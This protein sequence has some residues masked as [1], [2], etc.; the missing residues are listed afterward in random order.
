MDP[1]SLPPRK[2][3]VPIFPVVA[4]EKIPPFWTLRV[5]TV[6]LPTD[7]FPEFKLKTAAERELELKELGFPLKEPVPEMVATLNVPAERAMA[8]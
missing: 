5:V 3:K 8:P 4:T 2:L 7:A 6:K 1:A